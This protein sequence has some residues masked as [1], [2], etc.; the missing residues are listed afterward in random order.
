MLWI[1]EI[2]QLDVGLLLQIS[3]LCFCEG[4]RFT[5][6]GDFNQFAPIGNNFRGTPIAED[7]LQVSNLLHTM[8][9]GNVVTLTECRRSDKVL[10]DFYASLVQIGLPDNPTGLIPRWNQ[11]LQSVI[12]VAKALFNY[13]G[14]CRSNLVIS[15]KKRILLN[16]QI[17][18]QM[19]PCGDVAVRLEVAGKQ[20]RGNAAQS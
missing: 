14:F 4:F 6:S 18:E 12:A 20:L 9:S 10:F 13:G 5:L 8:A 7:A 1:D 3:K 15:H 17:N 11:P 16:H 2:S 19:A